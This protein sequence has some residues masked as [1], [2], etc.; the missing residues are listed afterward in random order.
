KLSSP[1]IIANVARQSAAL[2]AGLAT[3]NDELKMFSDVRGRG[4]MLGA[5]LADA[6]RGKAGAIL[7][8]AAGE[9]LLLL[10][11]GPDVLRFVPALNIR[12]EDVAEGLRRLSLSLHAFVSAT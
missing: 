5:V 2:R 9:G 4:L 11:A 6:H 10:Q 7:D 8:H 3:I 1:E 12:D